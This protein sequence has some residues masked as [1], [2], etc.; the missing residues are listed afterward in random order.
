MTWIHI[1]K[2]LYS[3]IF[4]KYYS[5]VSQIISNCF[6][7]DAHSKHWVKNLSLYNLMEAKMIDKLEEKVKEENLDS[8]MVAEAEEELIM[9]F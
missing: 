9:K 1:S 5:R 8:G 4:P 3:V 7:A 2:I 6:L